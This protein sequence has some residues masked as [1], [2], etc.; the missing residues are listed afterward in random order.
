M[1]PPASSRG[2]YTHPGLRMQLNTLQSP[3]SGGESGK[4]KKKPVEPNPYSDS[5]SDDLIVVK[6]EHCTIDPITKKQI[7]DPVRNKKCNHIY[8]KST[9]YG[10]I[11]QVAL[12]S[13]LSSVTPCPTRPGRRASRSG[14]PTW[15]ATRRTSRRLISSRIRR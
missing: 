14:V 6:T 1:A 4:K 5:D 11:E 7:T 13:P 2:Y 9:I 15:A 10:M 8:Q 12:T 3:S